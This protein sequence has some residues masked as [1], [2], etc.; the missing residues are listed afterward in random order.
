MTDSADLNPF[1]SGNYCG[2][3]TYVCDVAGRLDRVRTFDA[4]ACR[5]ALTVPGLQK[6]VKV[7]IER[8]LKMM[9]T[10]EAVLGGPKLENPS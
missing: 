3:D 10:A 9:R 6:T 2:H 5:A 1:Y 4:A 8:R 7:A